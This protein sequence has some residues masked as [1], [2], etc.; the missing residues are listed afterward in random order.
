MSASY[1]ILNDYHEAPSFMAF[2]FSD[3]NNINIQVPRL[4]GGALIGSQF[5]SSYIFH[6]LYDVVDCNFYAAGL[7][8]HDDACGGLEQPCAGVSSWFCLGRLDV[9]Q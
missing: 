8:L 7:E 4:G 3:Y 5:V 6:G 2:D 1:N 9:H